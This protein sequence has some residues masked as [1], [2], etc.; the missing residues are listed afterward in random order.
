MTMP[1]KKAVKNN[2]FRPLVLLLLAIALLFAAIVYTVL[3]VSNAL[4]IHIE[5]A[6]AC[7]PPGYIQEDVDHPFHWT[8]LNVGQNIFDT[9]EG[10]FLVELTE[11][12]VAT[13]VHVAPVSDDLTMSNTDTDQNAWWKYYEFYIKGPKGIYGPV[14]VLGCEG[15]DVYIDLTEAKFV[16]WAKR[17][18]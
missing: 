18:G 15:G 10:D 12:E 5:F 11:K 8:I 4:K 7:P 1:Q 3:N 14:H 6:P 17:E 9:P 16:E 2:R 13:G